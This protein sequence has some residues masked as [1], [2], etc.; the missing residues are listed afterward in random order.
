M[1]QKMQSDHGRP[2][3]DFCS[4]STGISTQVNKYEYVDNIMGDP[5]AV[6]DELT[7]SAVVDAPSLPEGIECP[8]PPSCEPSHEQDAQLTTNLISPCFTGR[9]MT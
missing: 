9:S 2:L 3:I 7:C 5:E 6:V 8:L 1:E 4:R